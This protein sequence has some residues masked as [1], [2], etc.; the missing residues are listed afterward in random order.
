MVSI[1]YTVILIVS[2]LFLVWKKDEAESYFPLKI[3]GYFIL[4][5]FA[6]NFNQ[7]TVPLGFIVYLLFFRPTL[8]VDVKRMASIFGV[9]AFILVHWILPF[10]IHEWESRPIFIEHELGSVYTMNF[11]GEYGLIK[12]E[13]K[14]ENQNLRLENFGVDY[15]KDGRITDLSWQLLGQNGNSFNLYHIRYDINKSSYRVTNSQP[16]TWLQYNRL[17]GAEH[18]FENLN[19]L[20]IK[21]ITHAKGDFSSYVIRSSGERMNYV[22]EN[23]PHFFLSNGE[24][25]L[26][27]DEQLP[28]EAYYIST[29]AMKKTGEKR[30]VQGNI[31][32]ES[33][34]GTE[35]SDYLFDVKFGEE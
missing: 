33:F 11:Q 32:Q 15:V 21:D 1:V 7:I 20:D 27:D 3:I 24:I 35:S 34:E 18:F 30:N 4:G 25:Q 5:S 2:F 14:L 19:V 26:L 10:A 23:E 12:Q 16:D 22:V 31:T 6:F 9:L 8:N 29:F 13:L 28:V 17:I